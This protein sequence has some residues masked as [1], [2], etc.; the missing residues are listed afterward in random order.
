MKLV[1]RTTLA[2]F[3][4][5]FV[6]ARAGADDAATWKQRGDEAMDAG[7]AAE[8][9]DAYRR[10]AAIAPSPSLDFNVGRALLATGDFVGALDA[11]ERYDASAPAELKA[12][13]HR[14]ADVMVEIR[15]KIVS[16]EVTGDAGARVL[17]D[18]RAQ[19]VLPSA[20]FRHNPGPVDLNVEAEDRVPFVTRREL[21]P[22][23]TVQIPVVLARVA[24]EATLTVVVRPQGARVVVDGVP[25]GLAPAALT[26]APGSHEVTLEASAH[27]PRKMAIVLGRAES[28]RIDV[29]LAPERRAITSRGW[30]WTGVGVLVAGATA[31]VVALTTERSPSEGSLGTVHVP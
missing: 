15:A 4:W 12:K 31:A 30:F 11:F 2:L 17:V 7:R 22:G 9:L 21:T 26:L 1:K 25:M 5:M 28:R 16:V 8:A 13:T 18:G 20:P 10:A 14:L 27:E 6:A 29:D 24:I 23:S 19:C 3:A